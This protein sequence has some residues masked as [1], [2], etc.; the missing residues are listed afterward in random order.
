MTLM[1]V[2]DEG[3]TARRVLDG[4]LLEPMQSGNLNDLCPRK[5]KSSTESPPQKGSKQLSDF[6]ASSVVAFEFQK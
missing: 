2:A 3:K 5:P 1:A 6:E 4:T